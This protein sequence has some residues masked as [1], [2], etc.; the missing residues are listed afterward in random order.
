V[1]FVLLF[2]WWS[3]LLL[4]L[5][6]APL[7]VHVSGAGDFQLGQIDVLKDPFPISERKNSDV[8]DS[9]DNQIQVRYI[10]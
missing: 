8:M 7:K 4:L 2:H 10:G 3:Y 9:D 5:T 6:P 1:I